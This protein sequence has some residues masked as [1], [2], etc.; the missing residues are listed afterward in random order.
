MSQFVLPGRHTLKERE[1][2]SI[3]EH[4]NGHNDYI[5]ETN[6]KGGN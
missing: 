4:T 3:K 5:F 2:E 6:M 1:R